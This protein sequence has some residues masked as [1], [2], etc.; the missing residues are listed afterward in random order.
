MTHYRLHIE[1]DAYVGNFVEDLAA[2]TTMCA[3]DYS[4]YI[5]LD[6]ED[7]IDKIVGDLNIKYP[8]DN[9]IGWFEDNYRSSWD[10]HGRFV[11]YRMGFNNSVDIFFDELP[12]REL[13][14]IYEKRAYAFKYGDM[15]ITSMVW[16]RVEK[17]VT[18]TTCT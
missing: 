8:D 9:A 3:C 16:Q 14:E 17:I 12:P 10:S 15:K 7:E 4:K 11:H 6:F 13:R 5:D 18:Y 2:W 1:T